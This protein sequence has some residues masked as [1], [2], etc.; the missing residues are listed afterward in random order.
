MQEEQEGPGKSKRQDEMAKYMVE[1]AQMQHRDE[2]VDV[3]V[4]CGG[5]HDACF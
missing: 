1:C 4:M 5:G 3:Q 2:Q